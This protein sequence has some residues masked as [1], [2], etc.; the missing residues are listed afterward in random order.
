MTDKTE[1]SR[2][3]PALRTLQLDQRQLL[4]GGDRVEHGIRD[5][6]PTF[7]SAISWYQRAIVRTFGFLADEIEPVDLVRDRTLTGALVVGPERDELV[8]DP[9]RPAL[10]RRYRRVLERAYIKPACN[11]AYNRLRRGAGEYLEDSNVSPEKV[12]PGRQHHVAMRPSLERK[13]VEQSEALR[14]LWGGFETESALLDWLHDLDEPANGAIAANFSARVGK[15]ATARAHLI[16]SEQS[17]AGVTDAQASR[18]REHFATTVVLPAFNRGIRRLDS[19]GELVEQ[20]S[21]GL[22][23]PQG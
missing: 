7:R 1:T 6:F 13:D 9:L 8:D 4:E 19:A 21:T 16:A 20:Q 5:G 3:Q 22:S 12:D 11:R 2:T 10:A 17:D 18:W 23:A 15:D 14:K